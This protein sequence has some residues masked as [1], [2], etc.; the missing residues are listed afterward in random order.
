M[1]KIYFLFSIILIIFFLGIFQSAT[2]AVDLDQ[3][4]NMT[5][6]IDPRMNDASL[7]I[8]YEITW[9]VLNSTIED[10]L[11]GYR[12]ERQILV[13]ITLLPFQIIL[14]KFRNIIVVIM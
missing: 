5:V 7:D 4:E 9:K 6:T 2:Y 1:K 10:L 11:L 14:K 8:Q 12:L 13:L 3:I